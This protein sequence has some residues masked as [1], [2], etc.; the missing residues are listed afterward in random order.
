MVQNT[1]TPGIPLRVSPTAER[2]GSQRLPAQAPLLTR[3]VFSVLWETGFVFMIAEGQWPARTWGTIGGKQLRRE[4]KLVG[5]TCTPGFPGVQTLS[6]VQLEPLD[7]AMMETG[8]SLRGSRG[9]NKGTEQAH[10]RRSRRGARRRRR[11]RVWRL[12][13]VE[14]LLSSVKVYKK[15]TWAFL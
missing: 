10:T 8:R 7:A 4:R 2:P 11:G 1:A 15:K 9:R 14:L 6:H 5:N 13:F 3:C 12:S